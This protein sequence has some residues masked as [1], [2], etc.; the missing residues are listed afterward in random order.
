MLQVGC[1][2][3][4]ISIQIDI[5]FNGHYGCNLACQ[6]SLALAANVALAQSTQNWAG[7]AS[8]SSKYSHF[9]LQKAKMATAKIQ[10]RGF[11]M[12][13]HKPMVDVTDAT[14]IIYT[15]HL[16]LAHS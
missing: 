10:T 4:K 6:L 2:L 11:K 12:A 8:L 14:S 1:T 9:W 3:A 15:P 13:V 5:I 16:V 7:I